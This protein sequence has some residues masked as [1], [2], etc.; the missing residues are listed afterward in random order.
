AVVAAYVLYVVYQK[1]NE[2]KQMKPKESDDP[3]AHFEKQ[4]A[5]L[6]RSL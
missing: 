6:E 1:W 4:W 2:T 3:F 5:E